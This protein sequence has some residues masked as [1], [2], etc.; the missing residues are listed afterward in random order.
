MS[1]PVYAEDSSLL[2]LYFFTELHPLDNYTKL[3]RLSD[4]VTNTLAGFFP[5]HPPTTPYVLTYKE[6]LVDLE[7]TWLENQITKNP[8]DEYPEGLVAITAF[9]VLSP[10]PHKVM[11]PG[12]AARL[13][14]IT[15]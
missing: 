11:L 10:G 2:S 15:A 14:T 8:T 1:G 7:K 9:K 4:K 6:T 13:S 3:I 12:L 5:N